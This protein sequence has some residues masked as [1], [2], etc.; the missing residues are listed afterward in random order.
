[1]GGKLADFA[2]I[3]VIAFIGIFIINKALTAVGLSNYKA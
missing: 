1:M 3:A 2:K